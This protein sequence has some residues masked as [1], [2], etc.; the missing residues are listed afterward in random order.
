MCHVSCLPSVSRINNCVGEYNQKFFIQ[1]L[2]YVGE[3][4]CWLTL[5]VAFNLRCLHSAMTWPLP[6]S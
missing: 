2:F 6:P 1:F 3:D 5:C 4:R